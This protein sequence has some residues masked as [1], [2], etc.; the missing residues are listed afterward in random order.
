MNTSRA[1]SS[2]PVVVQCDTSDDRRPPDHQVGHVYLGGAVLVAK[3]LP[4]GQL[5]EVVVEF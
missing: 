3:T 1:F 2:T 4:L 5:G